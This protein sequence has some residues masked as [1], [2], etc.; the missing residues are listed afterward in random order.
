MKSGSHI[1]TQSCAGLSKGPPLQSEH[2]AMHLH[3]HYNNP[4]RLEERA[5]VWIDL[6]V[7][8]ARFSALSTSR[9]WLLSDVL[10]GC[11][12]HGPGYK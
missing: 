10:A 11:R 1:Q 2:A 6:P 3:L 4:T 7:Y 12:S 8:I 9:A 5:S